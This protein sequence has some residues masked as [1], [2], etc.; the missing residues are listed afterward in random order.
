[1]IEIVE[2]GTDE[3]PA[4]LLRQARQLMDVAFGDDPEE[5]FGDDDWEHGLGGVHVLLVEHGVVLTHAALVERTLHAGE[6]P[7]RTGYVEAVATRPDREGEGLGSRAMSRITD[8]VRSSYDLGA[9]GTGR[10]SF[11]ERL[12]WERWRGP[13]YVRT[14]AGALERTEEDDDGVMVLRTGPT[15]DLDLEGPLA[16]EERPGDVW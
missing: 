3:V 14:A 11:Y 4:D 7:L 1:V 16:C 2:A 15:A 9:L 5:A 8:L 6:R 12:G 13:T 10:W